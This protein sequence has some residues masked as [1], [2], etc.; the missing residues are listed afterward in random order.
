M[1]GWKCKQCYTIDI[2]D[3]HSARE[4]SCPNESEWFKFEYEKQ[5]EENETLKNILK[6]YLKI[7]STIPTNARVEVAEI[8]KDVLKILS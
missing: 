2:D 7:E 6:R 8:T 4:C 5:K 1:N 3:C